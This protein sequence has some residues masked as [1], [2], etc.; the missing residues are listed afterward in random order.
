MPSLSSINSTDPG[1]FHGHAREMRPPVPPPVEV[2]DLSISRTLPSPTATASSNLDLLPPPSGPGYGDMSYGNP[3]SGRIYQFPTES[4]VIRP[5]QDPVQNW[6]TAQDGPWTHVSTKVTPV[7]PEIISDGRFQS[8]QTGSRNHNPSGGQYRQHIP[9]DAGSSFHFGA[10]GVP[11]SDSGYGTR[12]SVANTSVFSGDA[13]ERDQDCQSLVGH[14]E[15][16][17]SF[18]GYNEQMQQRDA[19][20]S[21][22][23]NTSVSSQSESRGLICP[24]CH[25]TVKTQSEMKYDCHQSCMI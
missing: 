9:S 15:N 16:Y 3:N 21:E 23:W 12:R 19:R 6:Y 20:S 22:P 13:P 5:S 14:V 7:M 1:H 2:A 18:I 11:H 4:Q 8:K 10:P 25:K 24:V 17:Q